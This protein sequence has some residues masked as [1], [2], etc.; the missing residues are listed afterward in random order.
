MNNIK[1]PKAKVILHTFSHHGENISDSYYWLRDKNWPKVETPEIL[2]Y[3]TLENDYYK[4]HENK[5][6]ERQIY[7]ELKGRIKEEDESY[8]IKRDDF[9][10]FN[11][12]KAGQN[13]FCLYRRNLQGQ[14][15]LLLDCNELA[16]G[17]SSFAMGDVS[18]T[19]DHSKIAYAYDSD[20]SE[21]YT[22]YVNTQE[23]NVINT[24][25]NIIWNKGGT[26]FYYIAL[27]D[28]WRRN[29]VY[30]HKLGTK[31]IEDILIY[32]ELDPVFSIGI[33]ETSD[34]NFLLINTSSSISS[35]IHYM[36]NNDAP[37]E[38]KI[39]IKRK[40]EHLYEIDHMYGK[41]YLKTNDKG[42]NFRLLSCEHFER[43]NFEEIIAH[44]SNEYLVDFSLYQK[45]LVV[46]KS[47]LG[48]NKMEYYNL[49]DNKL[50][51]QVEFKEEVYE[52]NVAYTNKQDKFLRIHYSSLTTPKSVLEYDF[53]TKILHTR[54]TDEVP[55]YDSSK[56]ECKRLWAEAEDGVKIPVSMVYCKDKI[57]HNTTNPLLLYGY[58]SYGYGMP[59]SF[60]S[61]I[62]SLLDRGFIYVIAHIRGGDE[63]GYEWYDRA[64][65]LTKKLTF[66][67]FISAAEHLIEQKYTDSSKL[68]IMGGSAGG[69]LMGAVV[70]MRPELFKSVVALVPFVDVLNTMLDDSLPLT[71][72]EFEEWGN[73]IANKEY[74]DYIK[75]YSP[76]DNVKMQNYPAMLVTAGLTDPRVGYWEAAKW[77]AKLRATKTN[78]NLLLLKTEMDSGHQG[79]SGRFKALEEVAM[80]Y[81]FVISTIEKV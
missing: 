64:K 27:D 7:Q 8:P 73:P 20:G 46:T 34:N 69:M 19:K 79:Q 58:G 2:E 4:A 15:V 41:F 38:L 61:N 80:I 6:L 53:S 1:P 72:G 62:V 42:K 33:A 12:I 11:R 47:I 56:Y 49:S 66:E 37:R 3:L 74:F 76:Y 50:A 54:K 43:D 55:G 52:S 57:K 16:T 39:A 78:D 35:E 29:R 17:K 9:Y 40:P 22:I 36:E 65:F 32:H 21:R 77:V 28:N 71:P 67:D 44:N 24:I 5:D 68:A 31:Q 60:R 14:E 30:Y 26:G 10:Y 75:S 70:N 81:S 51:G 59:V 18:I 23:D 45:Y 48:L 25:G 13:Y 63:L